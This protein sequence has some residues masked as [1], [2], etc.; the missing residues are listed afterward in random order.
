[1]ELHG[2]IMAK[3]RRRAMERRNA[4]RGRYTVHTQWVVLRF[5]R[6]VSGRR[7][8]GVDFR[9]I[10]LGDHWASLGYS[11]GVICG[12]LVIVECDY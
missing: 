10:F 9:D 7:K 3:M 12:P 11:S 8:W 1:M 2:D 5:R 4:V 6:R